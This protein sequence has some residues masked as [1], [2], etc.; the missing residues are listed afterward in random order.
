MNECGIIFLILWLSLKCGGLAM[1]GK[2]VSGPAPWFVNGL[3][4]PLHP[5]LEPLLR[6][7]TTCST[8]LLNMFQKER[9]LQN[10]WNMKGKQTELVHFPTFFSAIFKNRKSRLCSFCWLI[11]NWAQISVLNV[12]PVCGPSGERVDFDLRIG[13][14]RENLVWWFLGNFK[15][16]KMS[17]FVTNIISFKLYMKPGELFNF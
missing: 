4:P 7:L 5:P 13:D 17:K 10:N 12:S 9:S 11:C 8:S 14:F 1:L 6:K 3:W 2:A 15:T 16:F